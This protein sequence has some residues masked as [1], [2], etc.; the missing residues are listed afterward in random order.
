MLPPWRQADEHQLARLRPGQRQRH[1]PHHREGGQQNL[2][3]TPAPEARMPTWKKHHP[4]YSHRLL[5]CEYTPPVRCM[6]TNS[7]EM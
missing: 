1:A 6:A 4:D 5:L 7:T 3:Q 2:P